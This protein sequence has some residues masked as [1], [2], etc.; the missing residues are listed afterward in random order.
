MAEVVCAVEPVKSVEGGV[1]YPVPPMTLG[2]DVLAGV[3]G[4]GCTILFIV[5]LVQNDEAC[6]YRLDHDR[7]CG[8]VIWT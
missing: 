6:V 1:I 2:E 3:L 5:V 4:A 8:I 7:I